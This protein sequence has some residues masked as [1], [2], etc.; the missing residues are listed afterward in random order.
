M[1]NI[2]SDEDVFYDAEEDPDEDSE[3]D[4]NL[5]SSWVYALIVFVVKV[6]HFQKI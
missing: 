4:G 3:D 6:A 2:E 1:K 5:S